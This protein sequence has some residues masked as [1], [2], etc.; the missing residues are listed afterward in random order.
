MGMC[1]GMGGVGT[2]GGLGV[3]VGGGIDVDRLGRNGVTDRGC[4]HNFGGQELGDEGPAGTS[5]CFMNPA[6][7][8]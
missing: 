8:R 7:L 3:A 2:D 1:G 5:Q 4:C 6:D